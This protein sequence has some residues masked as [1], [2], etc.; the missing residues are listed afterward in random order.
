MKTSDGLKRTHAG[1]G[2]QGKLREV[3]FCQGINWVLEYYYRGVASWTWFYPH[4]FSPMISDMVNISDFQ[5]VFEHGKPF[6][7]FQQLLSVLPAASCKLLPAPYQVTYFSSLTADVF[8]GH[9]IEDRH[10]VYI[11]PPATW[12][13]DDNSSCRTHAH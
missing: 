7:P 13:H 10:R 9:W 2:S 12:C 8:K 3:Y 6:L 4:H 1:R 5:V 11:I